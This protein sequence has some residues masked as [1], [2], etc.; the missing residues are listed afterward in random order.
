[1]SDE[2]CPSCG[3]GFY[4]YFARYRGKYCPQCGRGGDGR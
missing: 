3:S 1:M 4:G 2:F